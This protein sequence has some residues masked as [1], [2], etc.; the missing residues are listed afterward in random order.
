[1]AASH[2]LQLTAPARADSL[3]AVLQLDRDTLRTLN[4]ALRNA[5]WNLQRP[6][7]RGYRL[8]L[9]DSLKSW[10]GESLAA[11]LSARR[12]QA[13]RWR[14]PRCRAHAPQPRGAARRAP[15]PALAAVARGDAATGHSLAPA[16]A[17]APG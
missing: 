11:Q 12:R 16:A 9:P 10:T 17:A 14:S 13:R 15:P 6:I 8:R 7:P 3:A 2:E 1:M 5:V 4:P